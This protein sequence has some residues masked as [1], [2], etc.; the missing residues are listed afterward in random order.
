MSNAAPGFDS[1]GHPVVRMQIGD[2]VV[3]VGLTQS[4]LLAAK[5]SRQVAQEILEARLQQELKR[6]NPPKVSE[7]DVEQDWKLLEKT[8][9]TTTD[10]IADQNVKP[11]P[12]ATQAR[13][14]RGSNQP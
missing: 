3:N 13:W 9:N 12:A 6:G 8:L 10:Q 7:S 4:N 2:E 11:L 1:A 14:N 5:S